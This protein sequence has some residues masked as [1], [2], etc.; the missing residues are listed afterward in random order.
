MANVGALCVCRFS[1]RPEMRRIWIIVPIYFSY[2]MSFLHLLF[3]LF[4]SIGLLRSAGSKEA[5]GHRF[6][7]KH[8][9]QIHRKVTEVLRRLKYLIRD[10]TLRFPVASTVRFEDAKFTADFTPVLRNLSDSS[11]SGTIECV[12]N[13]TPR[14]ES[15]RVP[16]NGPLMPLLT[17]PLSEATLPW[18]SQL[19]LFFDQRGPSVP[20]TRPCPPH[21]P[22]RLKNCSFI[23]VHDLILINSAN[24]IDC[25]RV[26]LFLRSLRSTGCCA[27]VVIF[28]QPASSSSNPMGE[29][30]EIESSCGRV[31]Y[32]DVDE[33]PS[34]QTEMKIF[35]L[36]LRF[37]NRRLQQLTLSMKSSCLQRVILLDFEEMFAQAD[38]FSFSYPKT[39]E[40]VLTD[41]GFEDKYKLSAAPYK[42]ML[43]VA[44]HQVLQKN[45]SRGIGSFPAINPKFI[46]GTFFGVFKL[47][48]VFSH[49]ADLMDL[50][51]DTA[52]GKG[53]TRLGVLN[54]CFYSGLLN[55]VVAVK[56]L[57]QAK[58]PF[59]SGRY[60]L[61]TNKFGLNEHSL[62]TPVLRNG[63]L[64]FDFLL[65][66][67]VNHAGE[68]FAFIT[69]FSKF[70]FMAFIESWLLDFGKI[71][72][73]NTFVGPALSCAKDTLVA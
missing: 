54:L 73:Q 22:R 17:S 72:Y 48:W 7:S 1:L 20:A 42:D 15:C 32:E 8:D 46:S 50:G 61:R 25:H 4:V 43:D 24:G 29:C 44:S 47:L 37:L 52:A 71:T 64:P 11:A 26:S 18:S 65:N 60:A 19:E 23:H 35:P 33:F 14:A 27:E 68:P 56:L 57:P 10:T 34:V 40:V 62:Y 38:P 28:Q 3:W 49:V 51:Y 53:A 13:D 66:P 67:I 12:R 31:V 59:V 63:S 55:R 41:L 2:T 6:E 70:H 30:F 21:A 69:H 5:S 58:S 36:Y 39:Q 16:E 45:M 9:A